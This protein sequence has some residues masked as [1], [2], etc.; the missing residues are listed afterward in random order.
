MTLYDGGGDG[1]ARSLSLSAACL[2]PATTLASSY[3]CCWSQNGSKW[4]RVILNEN[5]GGGGG[6]AVMITAL[7]QAACQ[8]GIRSCSSRRERGKEETCVD[9]NL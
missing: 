2:L 8:V 7:V 9:K 6:S 1:D 4:V 5:G 3:M